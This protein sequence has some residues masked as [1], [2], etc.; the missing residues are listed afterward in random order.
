[1]NQVSP[2]TGGQHESTNLRGLR[3]RLNAWVLERLLS[4]TPKPTEAKARWHVAQDIIK[5]INDPSF[6]SEHVLSAT[7]ESINLLK[8]RGLSPETPII[9]SNLDSLHPTEEYETIFRRDRLNQCW[10]AEEISSGGET[11][12]RATIADTGQ[13]LLTL[14]PQGERFKNSNPSIIESSDYPRAAVTTFNL[15]VGT[16][17]QK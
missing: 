7:Q 12:S 17:F 9:I 14:N 13:T 4:W 2:E 3:R 1:M 16:L 10:I 15:L 8:D 11:I 5:D 6:A